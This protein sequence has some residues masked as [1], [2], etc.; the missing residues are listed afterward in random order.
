MNDSTWGTEGS[1]WLSIPQPFVPSPEDLALLR[2]ACAAQL[3]DGG[4]PLRVLMLGVTPGLTAIDWPDGSTLDAVDFDPVMIET[5]WRD[6]EGASC[7]CAPWQDMPFPDDHFDVVIGDC[8]F[9]A[10]PAIAD[11]DGVLNEV[12]RILRP[13]GTLAV[14]F[15]MQPAPRLTLAALMHDAAE[16]YAGFRDAAM[17]LMIPMASSDPDGT[18]HSRAI[19]GKVAEQCGDLDSFLAALGQEGEAKERA[20]KT[21]GFDQRLNYPTREQVRT[22]FGRFFAEVDIVFPDYDCGFLCPM[23]SARGVADGQASTSA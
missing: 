21:F 16:K 15:F 18:S 20:L 8:S 5:L 2:Q 9:N 23:V 11:Y 12:L 13:S 1:L 19:P 6:R 10:L 7:H 22:I 17:R 14:R 4:A 3:R